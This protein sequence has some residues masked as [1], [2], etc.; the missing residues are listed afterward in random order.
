MKQVIEQEKAWEMIRGAKSAGGQIISA[1]IHVR[2]SESNTNSDFQK[3][4]SAILADGFSKPRGRAVVVW[5]EK[6]ADISDVASLW[7]HYGQVESTEILSTCRNL[8]GK[9]GFGET[10]K[11][12]LTCVIEFSERNRVVT[13]HDLAYPARGGEA[14]ADTIALRPFKAVSDKGEYTF[15]TV[16]ELKEFLTKVKDAETHR[17]D[18]KTGKWVRWV[19]VEQQEDKLVVNIPR[20]KGSKTLQIDLQTGKV[21]EKK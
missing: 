14:V 17:F 15:Q 18:D 2:I 16:P 9:A 20:Q 13:L 11:L 7:L 5:G 6:S 3:T 1:T 4:V 21:E 12:R 19:E 10:G 8:A